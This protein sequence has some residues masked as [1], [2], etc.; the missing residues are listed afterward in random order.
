MGFL[1]TLKRFFSGAAD[2]AIAETRVVVL[3][4]LKDPPMSSAE[5]AKDLAQIGAAA[6]KGAAGNAKVEDTPAVVTESAAAEADATHADEQPV[7]TVAAKHRYDRRRH[8]TTSIE[9]VSVCLLVAVFVIALSL[10]VTTGLTN[11]PACDGGKCPCPVKPACPAVPV[12][13]GDQ[14][15]DHERRLE[16]IERVLRIRPGFRVG[17]KVGSLESAP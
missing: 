17:E 4:D 10:L 16:G 5:V 11:Q 7:K 1:A 6:L 12:A 2:A 3:D 8:A 14:L 13:I 9:V 15:A